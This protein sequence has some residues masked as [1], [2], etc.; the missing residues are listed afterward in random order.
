MNDLLA[1]LQ[2]TL[3]HEIPITEHLGITVV[4][5][6]DECLILRA[7]FAQNINHKATAFAGSL[8]AL[9]TLAGWGLLWLVLKERDIAAQIVIHE[10]MTSYLRPVT[11]DFSARC[12]KPD[13]IHIVHLENTLRKRGKARLELQAEICEGEVVAVSFK[14]RYVVLLQGQAK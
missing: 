1:E 3:A 11:R 9:V 13:S 5:Y 14:G 7:P 4:S 12:C 10:S 8:N 6:E 2:T